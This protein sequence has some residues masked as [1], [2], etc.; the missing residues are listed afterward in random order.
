MQYTL[1]CSMVLW[2]P[3]A[4]KSP[5]LGSP[6]NILGQTVSH[7]SIKICK[8]QNTTHVQY[9][10]HDLIRRE[11]TSPYILTVMFGTFRISGTLYLIPEISNEYLSSV[12]C[13]FQEQVVWQLSVA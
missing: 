1:E 12:I 10:K 13:M 11:L 6:M 5:N 3:G 9:L 2:W 8:F 4:G 7:I